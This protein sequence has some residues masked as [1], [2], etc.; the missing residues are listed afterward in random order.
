M[1]ILEVTLD[2]ELIRSANR[3][4]PSQVSLLNLVPGMKVIANI[5]QVRDKTQWRRG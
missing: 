1:S 3:L 2:E 5:C 4:S